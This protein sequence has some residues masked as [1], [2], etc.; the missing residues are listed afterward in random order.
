MIFALEGTTRFLQR[1]NGIWCQRHDKKKMRSSP[2][3]EFV[4]LTKLDCFFES[5]SPVENF[6][7]LDARARE[8]KMLV[9]AF[10]RFAC[11][12]HDSRQCWFRQL[13]SEATK[14]WLAEMLET[15]FNI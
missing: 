15:R 2:R 1:I 12:I 13:S 7:L 3:R 4:L 9:N 8:G 11:Q 5:D 14:Q 6:A 10:G